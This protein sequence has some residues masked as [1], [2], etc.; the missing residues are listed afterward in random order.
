M[1]D[2]V[3]NTAIYM[4]IPSLISVEK[5]AVTEGRRFTLETSE[6]L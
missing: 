5:C 2:F 6:G 3:R 1:K 4:V